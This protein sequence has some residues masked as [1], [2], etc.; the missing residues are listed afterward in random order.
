MFQFADALRK[1][2]GILPYIIA[3]DLHAVFFHGGKDLGQRDLH[4]FQQIHLVIIFKNRRQSV[5]KRFCGGDLTQKLPA[6]VRDTVIRFNFR[7]RDII[8]HGDLGN[9]KPGSVRVQQIRGETQIERY[10]SDLNAA[11][12]RVFIRLFGIRENLAHVFAFQRGFQ[13][14]K[15]VGNIVQ[16]VVIQRIKRAVIIKIKIQ[17]TFFIRVE[18]I[19]LFGMQNARF[20]L[21]RC[22]YRR[23]VEF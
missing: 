19:A 6:F 7:Q 23:F 10:V 20:L 17:R 13:N 15:A 14:G 5:G 18:G 2:H 22:F 1:D 3:V 12:H 11:L 16:S 9:G 4:V 8:T 21:F